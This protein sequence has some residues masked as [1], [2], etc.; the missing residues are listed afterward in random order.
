MTLDTKNKAPYSGTFAVSLLTDLGYITLE[1]TDISDL[2]FVEDIFSC[3]LTGR[4]QFFDRVGL[5][6]YGPITGNEVLT[7]VYGDEEEN[8]ERSFIVYKVSRIEAAKQA[9]SQNQQMCELLFVDPTFIASNQKQYSYSWLDEQGTDIIKHISEKWIGAETF[10]YWDECNE[11]FDNY[12]SPWWTAIQNINWLL[13]KLSS[14]KY[15]NSGYLFFS[16]TKKSDS[17]KSLPTFN[18]VTFE[19]L[20]QQDT[21]KL[22]DKDDG[23]YAFE[24]YNPHDFN[25]ILS[26]EMSG[27]DRTK[28]RRLRGGINYGYNTMKK[29]FLNKEYNY[30]D[31]I[32]ETTILGE[33]SLFD[34]ISETSVYHDY[35]VENNLQ[36]MQ[37]IF[38]SEWIKRYNTQQQMSIVVRGHEKRYA[39]ALIEINWESFI[40]ELKF[41]LNHQG[42][43]LIRSIT[44]H[45]S[46]KTPSY[47]QKLVLIKN[48][49]ENPNN[50]RLVSSTKN[51]LL[52]TGNTHQFGK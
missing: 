16:N 35:T 29:S 39:G 2:F 9:N 11:S 12:Y 50:N 47:K 34:D 3:A 15:N 10:D 31:L 13:P 20:L 18:L 37:N 48:G 44:H 43:W 24:S 8:I 14:K 25:K 23:I 46:N 26:W 51:N 32:K 22:N 1:N 36:I 19:Q 6:E 52:S 30:K 17:E 7:I 38:Y 4:I 41:N 40:K 21:L 28:M 33:K 27:I 42:G 45:F 49:Y 5:I